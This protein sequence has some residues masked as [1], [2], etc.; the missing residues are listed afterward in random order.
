M[1]LPSVVEV[2]QKLIQLDTSNPPGNEVACVNYLKELFKKAGF[3]T[4]VFARESQRANLVVTLAGRGEAPPLLFYGHLD[5]VTTENQKWT[6]P[7][8]AG[9]IDENSYLWGRG[10]LDM[11]G[12]VA[13]LAVSLIEA[14]KQGITPAGDII[15]CAVAD[16]EAGGDFGAAYL[17]DEH[18]ELFKD[19]KYAIGEFGGFSIRFGGKTYY[20]IMVGEKQICHVQAKAKGVSGH[21]S[22]PIKNGAISKLAQFI[23]RLE[24][25]PPAIFI[26]PPVRQLIEAISKSVPQLMGLLDEDKADAVLAGLGPQAPIFAPLLRATV[27]PT[28]LAGSSILNVIPAEATVDLDCRLLPSQKPDDVLD[29]LNEMAKGLVD[30]ELVRYEEG[31]GIPD[32]SQFDMLGAIL[33]DADKGATAC[34]FILSGSTDG[35]HFK[36]LGIQT[37]GFTPLALPPEFDFFNLA[38]APDERVPT[39]ALQFGVEALVELM[40]R[41]GC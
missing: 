12:G 27:C 17:V 18:P 36:R 31:T 21:A 34:P 24:E 33:S 25:R 35:R 2:A 28:M 4:K 38:H 29:Y 32:M 26:E 3:E 41:Y 23:G 20:P 7:P 5:V 8:F 40:R 11:K 6:H 16:E 14:K 15:F 1:S 37:Y 10:S 22:V 13:M 9:H 30:I 19:V 39:S